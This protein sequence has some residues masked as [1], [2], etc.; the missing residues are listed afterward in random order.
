MLAD[1][2]LVEMERRVAAA[3]DPK[4]LPPLQRPGVEER[5]EAASVMMRGAQPQPPGDVLDADELPRAR[6]F[7]RVLSQLIQNTQITAALPAH[8]QPPLWSDPVDL[9]ATVSLPAAAGPYQ[10]VLTYQAPPG[11]W[12]RIAGYG[13]DVQDPLFT[14]DGSILWRVRVNG[15]NVQTLADW[16]EHRGSIIQPRVTEIFLREDWQVQFEVRRAVA[17]A[18]PTTIAMALTGWAWRLRHNYEGTKASIT[19]Y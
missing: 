7:A 12:A 11:R 8:V 13:V 5:L 4:P 1:Q 15:N 9:S 10:T 6:T 16:G 14:Y 19:S 17:A 2:G 3:S 18:L